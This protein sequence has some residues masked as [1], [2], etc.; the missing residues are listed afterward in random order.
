MVQRVHGY[1]GPFPPLGAPG[2]R[3]QMIYS[4]WYLDS[5]GDDI[6][7]ASFPSAEEAREHIIEGLGHLRRAAWRY[8][9]EGLDPYTMK[10]V[11]AE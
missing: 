4:V 2:Y 6:F 9:I 5:N 1:F 8:C 11:F 3:M 7:I 10:T